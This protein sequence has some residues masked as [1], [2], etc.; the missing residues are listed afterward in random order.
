MRR[1]AGRPLELTISTVAGVKN[2][3][4]IEVLLQ[5]MWR[6][7]G[8][9]LTIKNAPG[10]ILFAPAGAGGLLYGGKTQIA[11]FAWDNLTPDPD[12]ESTLGPN[13]LP[14]LGQNVSFFRDAR[15]GR[16][17]QAALGSYDAGFRRTK[18]LD[19]QRILLA[20]V[21]EYTLDWLPEID[22]ANVDLR[23]V[24]PVPV[25]SDFWNVATWR[26]GPH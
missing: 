14:P 21:P 1:K 7:L 20:Q 6:A 19:V 8:V 10:P 18:Y 9:A 13:R 15:I 12:D 17:Q 4:S 23:G 22:A 5:S 16:D 25:G 2:R 24:R 11:L 26:F 3:E